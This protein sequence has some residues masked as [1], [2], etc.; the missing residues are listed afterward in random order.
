MFT[1]RVRR[2]AGQHTPERGEMPLLLTYQLELLDERGLRSCFCVVT[3]SG[4]SEAM[5]LA[6]SMLAANYARVQVWRS[7][8]LIHEGIKSKPN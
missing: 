6:D 1:P 5:T 4:D 8:V 2:K 7:D 3:C